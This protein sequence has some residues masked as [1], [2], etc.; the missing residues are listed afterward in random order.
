MH[1]NIVRIQWIICLDE[2]IHAGGSRGY[3]LRSDESFQELAEYY[4]IT[5]D[6]EID[7]MLAYFHQMGVIL[8]FSY[9]EH[10]RDVI[11][12]DAR[13]VLFEIGKV[14]RDGR[15]QPFR[16]PQIDVKGL[17]PDVEKLLAHGMLSLDL[18]THLWDEERAPFLLDLMRNLL[19]LSSWEFNPLDEL[20]LVPSITNS[21]EES[22]EVDRAVKQLSFS[23]TVT[24]D[25]NE[26]L[27]LDGL[28]ERLICLLVEFAGHSG[29]LD[30]PILG[31]GRCLL[32]LEK[33]HVLV[34]TEGEAIAID[35]EVEENAQRIMN[36]TLAMMK[37]IR[38][39]LT[40][41]RLH[42]VLYLTT[43][44]DHMEYE[45]ARQDRTRPWFE[46]SGEHLVKGLPYNLDEFMVEW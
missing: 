28:I 46:V 16:S 31:R 24:F 18:A 17:E 6:R 1:V 14:V 22:A 15:I 30:E 34:R 37:K 42:W 3:V 27:L 5:D 39:D 13:W 33:S 32:Q 36:I 25:F 43:D 8:Y 40:K 44:M 12:T 21:L 4:G 29:G 45:D 19:L 35:I 23:C 10:L 20:Y 41:N 11:T 38:N 7:E 9:T 2:V 26:T